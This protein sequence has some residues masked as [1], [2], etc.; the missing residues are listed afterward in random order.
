MAQKFV[1]NLDLNS[2]Q[3]LNATLQKVDSDPSVGNFEGRLIYHTGEDVIKVYSGSAWRTLIASV[4]QAN[5]DGG[6]VS[7]GTHSTALTI[8][9]S[10]F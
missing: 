5:G 10:M 4:G 8:S 1:T 6:V 7:G 2:N 9:Q 3:L